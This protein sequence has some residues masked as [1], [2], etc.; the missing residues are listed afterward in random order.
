[1]LF[2]APGAQENPLTWFL[3][4]SCLIYPAL[5]IWG[6]RYTNKAVG[7]ENFKSAFIGL[8]VSYMAPSLVFA[9]NAAL[10]VF[11]NGKYAC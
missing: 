4:L 1:M 3:F 7:V 8:G 5:T 6:F 9:S 2:D 10:D 11:C